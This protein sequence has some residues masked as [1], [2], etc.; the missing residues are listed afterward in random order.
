MLVLRV[1][2]PHA[3]VSNLVELEKLMQFVLSVAFDKKVD[4][5]E[6]LGDLFHTHAVLR[7]EVLEFW[8]KWLNRFSESVYSVILVGNHD[9]TGDFNLETNAL[10]VF[11][12]G[13][14][15]T[16]KPRIVESPQVDGI[17]LYMPYYHDT[18]KFIETA[19]RW[20]SE[21]CKVLVSHQTYAG[22]QFENGFYAPDGINPDLLDFD[23]IISGHIHARQR[24][25]TKRGW[26]IYPGTARWDGIS[27]A[28]QPKGLWLVNHDDSTGAIINEEFIDTS[29]ICEPIYSIAWTED[30]PKPEIPTT[31]RISL[32]LIGS[33][34][35]ISQQK[36]DLKGKVAL[37]S[38]ITDK[39]KS[40]ARQAGANLSDFI[41]NLFVTSTDRERLISYMKELDLV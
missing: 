4:R 11:K 30:D 20:S 27:D 23:L 15:G 26:M 36:A 14:F 28:N 12:R 32:E 25:K 1:G 22:S 13:L 5:L 3:K 8:D 29:T 19:N 31:G 17:F 39:A 6:I 2:D 10:S 18:N 37:K 21:G 41:S 38:K 9:Q 16:Y 7:L 34:N 33:S 35:W 40:E 24:I